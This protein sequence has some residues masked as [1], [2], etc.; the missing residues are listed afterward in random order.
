MT[1]KTIGPDEFVDETWLHFAPYAYE[2]FL[3]KG[4][5]VIRIDVS[6]IKFTKKGEGFDIDVKSRYL[7]IDNDEVLDIASDDLDN[8]LKNY[9]PEREV[10]F[11]FVAG[12]KATLLV[13][14]P[15][16]QPSPKELYE[17]RRSS[18]Q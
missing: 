16:G 13:G 7:E 3:A 9:N 6:T 8:K 15:S 14:A 17:T 1:S 5:G 2:K 12:E 11:I 10:C 18:K 4:R